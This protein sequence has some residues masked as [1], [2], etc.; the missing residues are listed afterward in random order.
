M[1]IVFRNVSGS[2]NY[3]KVI[4]DVFLGCSSE[5]PWWPFSQNMQR[6]GTKERDKINDPNIAKITDSAIGVNRNLAAP[7][8]LKIGTKTIQIQSVETSAGNTI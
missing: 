2:P 6:L 8:K 7:D 4:L 1:Q 5:D 3:R